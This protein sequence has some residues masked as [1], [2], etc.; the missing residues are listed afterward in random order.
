MKFKRFN[1]IFK[2]EERISEWLQG[3]MNELLNEWMNER[4]KER[5]KERQK[6]RQKERMIEILLMDKSKS[7]SF[8]KQLNEKYK[9]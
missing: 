9:S 7:K 4:N 8:L 1:S 3:K 2:N 5:N 6:E